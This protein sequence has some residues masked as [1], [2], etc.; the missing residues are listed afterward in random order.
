MTQSAPRGPR[1]RRQERPDSHGDR[2]SLR[3]HAQAQNILNFKDSRIRWW[4][5]SALG[6]SIAVAVLDEAMVDVALPTMRADLP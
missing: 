4:V 5:A 2:R 1:T 6:L 3:Y